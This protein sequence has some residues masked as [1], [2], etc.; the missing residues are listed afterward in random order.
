MNGCKLHPPLHTFS[1]TEIFVIPVSNVGEVRIT[2]FHLKIYGRFNS[3][4]SLLA[5]RRCHSV[6]VVRRRLH[7][8]KIPFQNR[9]CSYSIL[10]QVPWIRLDALLARRLF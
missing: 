2:V 1:Q 4:G 3:T 5:P 7:T 8:R 6:F 10:E 9:N